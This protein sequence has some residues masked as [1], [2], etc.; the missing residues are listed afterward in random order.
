MPMNIFPPSGYRPNPLDGSDPQWAPWFAWFPVKVETFPWHPV[1]KET[2]PR[3]RRVWL[4]WVECR[5]T[6]DA[7]PPNDVQRMRFRL[8]T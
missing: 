4:R 2:D 6:P 3:L 7:S 1:R 8:P 5:E